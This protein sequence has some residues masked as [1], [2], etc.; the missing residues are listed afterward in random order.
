ME[1]LL[2]DG[3]VLKY[4][5]GFAAE[6]KTWLVYMKGE[7]VPVQQFKL[8][9]EAKKWADEALG[10]DQ[11]E[12]QQI[13][14]AEPVPHALMLVRSSIQSALTRT[15]CRQT[16]VYLSGGRNYRLDID[17]NYKISRKG[18]E[19]PIHFKAIHDYLL[20]AWDAEVTDGI[21][22]DDALGIEQVACEGTC[23]ATIDKDLDGIPGWHYNFIRQDLYDVSPE[24]A[25]L[26]FYRQCLV[27]D[28]TDDVFGLFRVGPKTAAKLL[29]EPATEVELWGV[30]V[31]EYLKRDRPKEDAVKNAKLLWIQREFGK[32]WEE[33]SFGKPPQA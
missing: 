19:K 3:D 8:Q 17:P 14:Q 4:R 24:Q 30:V 12:L 6:H 11:Y 7:H 1:R 21:E 10:K 31:E 29:P 28:D 32:I 22:A 33:P 26:N 20:R 9:R 18:K 16:T 27:G 15:G 13:V 23:I 2:V 5:C 25:T